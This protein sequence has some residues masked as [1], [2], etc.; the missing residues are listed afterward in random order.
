MIRVGDLMAKEHHLDLD[1]RAK[2]TYSR[3]LSAPSEMRDAKRL[4]TAETLRNYPSRFVRLR[5]VDL[6]RVSERQRVT[7][8]HAI[9]TLQTWCHFRARFSAIIRV[10]RLLRK[11]AEE[12]P[13]KADAFG[14]IV[15]RADA[16]AKAE[17]EAATQRALEEVEE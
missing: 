14:G 1:A 8:E 10:Q 2:L 3:E 13:R 11:I 15:S 17:A 12:A 9:H 7:I 16:F 6:D 5:L 4:Q